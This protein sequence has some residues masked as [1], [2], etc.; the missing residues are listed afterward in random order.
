MS[1]LK[2]W[3]KADYGD[4]AQRFI[5]V[6][7]SPYDGE[8]D[9]ARPI[10]RAL[11][12]PTFKIAAVASIFIGVMAALCVNP[13]GRRQ[14]LV[15]MSA[16]S[17]VSHVCFE[18]RFLIDQDKESPA[19]KKVVIDKAG[20]VQTNPNIFLN[21][22]HHYR[23]EIVFRGFCLAAIPTWFGGM[24]YFF[25]GPRTHSAAEA[26]ALLIGSAASAAVPYA[27]RLGWAVYARYQIGRQE[28]PWTVTDKPPPLR[29]EETQAAGREFSA[30]LVPARVHALSAPSVTS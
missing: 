25:G 23:S 17:L 5:Y 22:E 12:S 13:A 3:F 21:I 16:A 28:R 29:K 27:C 10:R 2:S 8:P 14:L 20:R 11:R 7:G 1:F 24:V 9:A 15:I 4:P 19:L 30:A 18:R 6:D 26:Y